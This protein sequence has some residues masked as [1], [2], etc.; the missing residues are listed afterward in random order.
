MFGA[1]AD[2]HVPPAR[3]LRGLA[4]ATALLLL[5]I[6]AAIQFRLNAWIILAVIQI[7]Y[8]AYAP[9]FSISTTLVLARL[10][11]ARKEFGPVRSMATLG[12]MGGALLI[13]ALGLD[14]SAYTGYLGATIWFIVA[15]FTYFLPELPVPRSSV[16]LTWHERFGLDALTLLKNRDTRAVYITTTLFTIPLC[17]FY[18]YA[19]V[20]LH[21]LGFQR[22]SAWMSLAQVS[23]I[24][25]MAGLAWLL[26]NWRLKWIFACGLGLGVARFALCAVNHSDPLL[27]GIGL[28][29]ASFVFVFITA[30][31]YLDQNIE[32]GWRA[33][34]QALLTLMNGGVGG[35]AGY[36]GSGWWFHA[37]TY[38]D[39]T[40]WAVFWGGLSATVGGLLAFF[41]ITYRG[42]TAKSS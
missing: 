31:I 25:A 22:T 42:K 12:W 11:D 41:L 1:M 6:S 20:H 5:I 18:P 4:S 2:R 40:H 34:A 9:M 10:K 28:H 26:L 24:I 35:V 33:R 27:I 32:P 13:G 3:V 7:F 15:A 21:D 16:R 14:R 38:S 19:P 8:L 30:Q 37:C 36:V 29:G 17:A 39:V 23:E